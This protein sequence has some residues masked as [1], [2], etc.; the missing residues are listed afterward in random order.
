MEK[1]F[2][3]FVAWATFLGMCVL[4]VFA[5]RELLADSPVDA[6]GVRRGKASWYSR[7]ECCT[8]ANPNALMANGKPLVDSRYTCAMWDVPLGTVVRVR[9]GER[10]VD[11]V[12]TDRG[13][14]RRLG[15]CIDLTRAAFAKL[16]P[17]S[18]G[19]ID[20]SVEEV[21]P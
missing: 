18:R 9:H 19:V 2:Y 13:P 15:R 20:V 7:A 16:A 21:R 12:V 10:R 17:L 4:A 1:Q 8:R 14:A 11:C 6:T 3:S 5:A